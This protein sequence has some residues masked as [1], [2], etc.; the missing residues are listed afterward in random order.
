M[1]AEDD[2]FVK[3]KYVA[4]DKESPAYANLDSEIDVGIGSLWVNVHPESLVSLLM[5]LNEN[6]TPKEPE[7]KRRM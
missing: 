2:N 1:W 6:F 5:N 3:I 4:V 7:K